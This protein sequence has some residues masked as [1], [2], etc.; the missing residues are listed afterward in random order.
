MKSIRRWREA[1]ER[2]GDIP[3]LNDTAKWLEAP[4]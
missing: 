2:Q 3:L 1:C 4:F